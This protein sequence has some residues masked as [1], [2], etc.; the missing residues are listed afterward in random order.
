M[1]VSTVFFF[2]FES[3]FVCKCVNQVG[4]CW[5]DGEFGVLLVYGGFGLSNTHPACFNDFLAHQR[6]ACL[7]LLRPQIRLKRL[8][9]V[10][11]S[12]VREASIA[13]M[14]A[15]LCLDLLST[16]SCSHSPSSPFSLSPSFL[17][18]AAPLWRGYSATLVEGREEGGKHGGVN[19]VLVSA[20]EE[21][22]E[23]TGSVRCGLG[24]LGCLDM[25][26]VAAAPT[27]MGGGRGR[28][29]DLKELSET[30]EANG[31]SF[32][33]F[34]AN[35][36]ST[37]IVRKTKY[38]NPLAPKKS[39]ARQQN[40]PTKKTLKAH[41]PPT[42][43]PIPTDSQTATKQS[44][45]SKH[46]P[47]I[48]YAA[49]PQNL[50]WLEKSAV[51]VMA[52]ETDFD[53]LEDNLKKD[54]FSCSSI[55]FLASCKVLLSFDSIEVMTS[56]IDTN[57][58]L[59]SQYFDS[60]DRWSP[61]MVSYAR[62]SWIICYRIPLDVWD[63]DFFSNFGNHFGKFLGVDAATAEKESFE[64]AR[65]IICTE[66]REPINKV[67]RIRVGDKF[68]DVA[69]F[70]DIIHDFVQ[71]ANDQNVV[72]WGFDSNVSEDD[73]PSLSENLPSPPDCQPS[74]QPIISSSKIVD[75][76]PPNDSN[77]LPSQHIPSTATTLINH[78]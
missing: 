15:P 12:S 35:P 3:L 13:S 46:I 53:G 40:P 10:P 75:A 24:C 54:G 19:T 42:N 8:Q 9:P 31:H 62:S 1:R 72:F 41:F 47:Y 78:S 67:Q 57:H 30:I 64:C 21:Q 66:R 18:M 22:V 56:S 68:H 76:I 4:C 25:V 16:S 32:K 71:I 36:P 11:S 43:N 37:S 23:E 60:I 28:R 26:V 20:G 44:P 38:Q 7:L 2:K 59:L 69:I 65:I 74:P 48:P 14:A 6:S 39:V 29:L 5:I 49:S 17:S 55:K 34:V 63:K 51:G 33:V 70:E 50:A 61:D 45:L 77:P 52:E 58:D 27:A 73:A